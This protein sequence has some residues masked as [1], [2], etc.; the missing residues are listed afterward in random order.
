MLKKI[1]IDN[2]EL[3]NVRANN[4]FISYLNNCLTTLYIKSIELLCFKIYLID[5]LSLIW[6]KITFFSCAFLLKVHLFRL[7]FFQF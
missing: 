6:Q 5:K 4:N 1:I 7:S 3:F 2:I